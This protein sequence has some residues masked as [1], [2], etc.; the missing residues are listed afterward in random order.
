M[1]STAGRFEIDGDG[2]ISLLLDLTRPVPA[3]NPS[4]SGGGG[5]R[6][7]LQAPQ[8]RCSRHQ[9]GGLLGSGRERGSDPRPLP[10]QRLPR[11]PQHPAA[12]ARGKRERESGRRLPGQRHLPAAH[13]RSAA[14][15]VQG[16]HVRDAGPHRLADLQ[17]LQ[18]R[19]LRG[20]ARQRRTH[21]QP[22]CR[23]DDSARRARR[24]PH[25]RHGPQG[26]DVRGRLRRRG[27]PPVHDRRA[28]SCRPRPALLL[29]R[30]LQRRHGRVDLGRHALQRVGAPTPVRPRR[31]PLRAAGRDDPKR[32]RQL[33]RRRQQ[34]H[35]RGL[36][37]TRRSCRAS[38]A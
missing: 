38:T 16:P 32:R 27:G 3:S 34:V 1:P 30:R 26:N 4:R 21:L 18:G 17:L 31:R 8:H 33:R 23:R 37:P 29:R 12:G 7:G 19:Q 22:A 5:K 36:R 28:P 13:E 15:H 2:Y 24:S 9:R 20:Q 35:H 6:E 10:A 11:L 25:L 14:R